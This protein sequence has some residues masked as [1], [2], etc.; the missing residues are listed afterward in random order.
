MKSKSIII[1]DISADEYDNFLAIKESETIIYTPNMRDCLSDPLNR[2]YVESDEF[3]RLLIEAVEDNYIKKIY[4]DNIKKNIYDLLA[5]LQK[6]KPYESTTD[7]AYLL[8]NLN[9]TKS[10]LKKSTDEKSLQFYVAQY[11][12]RE[13]IKIPITKRESSPCNSVFLQQL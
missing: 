2:G 7:R 12:I 3:L 8:N 13:D 6:N 10:L 4:D 1:S 9:Y 5:Y 11:F